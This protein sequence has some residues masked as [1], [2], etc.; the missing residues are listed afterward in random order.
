M[1]IAIIMLLIKINNNNNNNNNFLAG[2]L[3][4][5]YHP[6]SSNNMKN[7]DD[8]NKELINNL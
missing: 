5:V 6:N 4:C 7:Y 3:R 8:D 2:K 1:I